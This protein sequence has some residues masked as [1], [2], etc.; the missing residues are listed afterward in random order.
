MILTKQ[1]VQNGPK[2]LELKFSPNKT[3]ILNLVTSKTTLALNKISLLDYRSIDKKQNRLYKALK[4][5]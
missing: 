4:D 2:R 3:V 5:F 1:H